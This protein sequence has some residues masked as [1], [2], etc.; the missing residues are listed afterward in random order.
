MNI[1]FDFRGQF[2][3]GGSTSRRSKS[4]KLNGSEGSVDPNIISSS[5]RKKATK[6]NNTKRN[7][8]TSTLNSSDVSANWVEPKD[9]GQRRVQASDQSAGH[10]YTGSD[11]RKVYSN[12]SRM[13][14][15]I[16][17]FNLFT[18]IAMLVIKCC[19][20]DVLFFVKKRNTNTTQVL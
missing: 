7:N 5:S 14:N 13:F 17:L 1:C 18:L 19:K 15:A 4:K 2:D 9:A 12:F 10:W 3:S 20:H 8:E 6:R 16:T 11:G